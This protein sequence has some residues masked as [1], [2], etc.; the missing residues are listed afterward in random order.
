VI[1][2]ENLH[3]NRVL[4][5]LRAGGKSGSRR[6]KHPGRATSLPLRFDFS[7]DRR[8]LSP[9]NITALIHDCAIEGESGFAATCAEFPEAN[10][11]GETLEECVVNLRA[12]VEDVLAYR[13][14]VAAK[15]L[16]QGDRLELLKA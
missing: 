3:R 16:S 12:A 9:M 15:S 1:G 14:D 5:L 11:Q 13:R 7:T 10:G 2:V 4:E 8:F 6:A